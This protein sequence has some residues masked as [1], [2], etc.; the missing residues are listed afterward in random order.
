MVSQYIRPGYEY[1]YMSYAGIAQGKGF[2]V[3][4]CQ[5]KKT[6]AEFIDSFHTYFLTRDFFS[7]LADQVR[8]RK[9]GYSESFKDNMIDIQMTVRPLSYSQKDTLMLIKE[10]CTP[11]LRIFLRAY[12]VSDVETLMVLADEYEKLK[13]SGKHSQ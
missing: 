5:Q 13:M 12:K 10:N 6:W 1:D 7:R 9:Q 11:S 2:E 3:V 8:Q 4:Y